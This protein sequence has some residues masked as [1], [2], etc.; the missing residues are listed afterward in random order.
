MNIRNLDLNLLLVFE[1]V[2]ATGNISEAARQLDLSQPAVSNALNRLRKQLDDPLFVREGNGVV[3]T[4]KSVTIIE[5]IRAAL[6]AIQDTIEQPDEFDPATSR[7]HFRIIVADPLEPLIMPE[8][9]GKIS[10][11]TQITYELLPPQRFNI[12]EALLQDRIDL[13]V[14]LM[15]ERVPGIVSE[16]LM[17]VDLV[18][19]ARIGHPRISGTVQPKQLMQEN[20]VGL[21]L[22][23][24]KLENSSKVTVWQAIEQRVVCHV[25]KVNSIPQIV[26]ATDL[27]GF[28]PRKYAE[29]LSRHYD[30][31]IINLDAPFSNQKFHLSWHKRH[32][33]DGPHKWLREQI[34]RA[35]G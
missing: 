14:F 34:V 7:R 29:H 18:A 6:K 26:A 22:V 10:V 13:A 20:H 1:A 32:E 31:Q 27:I 33:H 4:S 8:L 24:G 28:V 17:P 16:P 9:L 21:M 15:P 5:P 2:Y 19:L 23:P 11:D 35:L 12:E 25:H 3:P 30:L